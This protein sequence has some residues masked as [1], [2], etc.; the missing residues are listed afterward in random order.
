VTYFV[1][2]AAGIAKGSQ[3]TGKGFIG[4][5]TMDQIREIAVK[6]MPDLNSNDVEGA[7]KM[8]AGSA[9]SMGLEVVE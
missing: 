4:Q 7:S 9:R 5:I 3:T 8:I 6:K 2:K 1:K